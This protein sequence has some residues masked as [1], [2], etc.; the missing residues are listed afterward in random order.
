M[1][2][3]SQ[4]QGGLRLQ[5][6][7]LTTPKLDAFLYQIEA[8]EA[9]K[10]R[11][12]AAVFHEQG[13]GKTKIAVDL[14]L[15]WL[16]SGAVDTVLLVTKKSL[17]NNWQRELRIHSHITPRTLTLRPSANFH[18]FN[19]PA[20]VI[21]AHFEAVQK[22]EE[23]IQLFGRTRQLGIIIDE[24]ARLKNPNA[25][26]TRTF[27]RLSPAFKRRVI[28]TGTPVANRPEDIWSQ[29][30][31]L[32]QGDSL[33]ADFAEFRSRV[34]LDKRLAGNAESQQEFQDALDDVRKKIAPFSVRETKGSG[35][36]TLPR[37][38]IKTVMADWELHQ[39][40]LYQQIRN[41]LRATLVRDGLPVQED[42]EPMLRRLLRLVQVASN[43]RLLD[44]SYRAT[45][46]KKQVLDDILYDVH[47]N[48]EKCIVWT[49]FTDNVDWL[50]SELRDFGARRV[51]GKLGSDARERSV[52]AFM[53]DPAVEVLVATPSSAK[54]GLTLTA[55]NHV[56]FY[57]RNLSLDDYLQAQD[58]I[59]R[60]SQVKTCYV[61]NLVM[62]DSIDEW[63]SVLL[64]AKHAVAQLAQ[65]D[66]TQDNFNARMRYDFHDV[67]VE[68]LG[69]D[70]A[71][72]NST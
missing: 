26:M 69:M 61:H 55:A 44:M 64:E 28:M 39:F 25:S 2:V 52:S 3:E 51:H 49:S 22:E 31:F 46:G 33:G 29:V 42:E 6:E 58:R 7:P 17:L 57:D 35:V 24:S 63:V 71:E 1:E 30:W 65:G 23:R 12:Y 11:D 54:E 68:I 38:V 67:L 43:P 27:L 45:P 66:V 16:R 21:L 18:V 32:D 53:T 48:G 56:I 70:E 19:S 4:V 34:Q 37:K 50:A 59:H 9:I 72:V 41:E 10:D 13:L 8:V 15:H 62:P 5:R 20:R 36:V 60:I 47:D 14:L 40:E